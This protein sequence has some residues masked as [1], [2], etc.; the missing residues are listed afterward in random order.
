MHK[1]ISLATVVA[2]PLLAACGDA[3]TGVQPEDLAGTWT[4]TSI[5]AT[6]KADPSVSENLT[7]QGV[8][9][10]ITIEA[11]GSYSVTRSV[12]GGGS[13]TDTGTLIVEGNTVT[14]TTDG[15]DDQ[16]SG[17][18]TRSGDTLTLELTE[19]AEHDFGTGS[20]EPANYEITFERTG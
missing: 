4:S 19:G 14:L 3:T 20:D 18:I 11:S 13:D 1:R 5:I 8:T 17:T 16:V 10:V 2:L 15:I 7:D 9:D 6:S 12:E